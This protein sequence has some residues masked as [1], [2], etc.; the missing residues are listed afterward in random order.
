M[1]GS[2]LLGTPCALS[3][4]ESNRML[5]DRETA[6][7]HL[8]D[9]DDDGYVTSQGRFVSVRSSSVQLRV[10]DSSSDYNLP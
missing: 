6:G 9:A 1:V 2:L 3:D 10:C 5:G 7:D 8:A 4:S